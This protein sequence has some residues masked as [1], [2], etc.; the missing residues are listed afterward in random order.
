LLG[1]VGAWGRHRCAHAENLREE[2][3]AHRL[4]SLAAREADHE[5]SDG[6][7]S[8]EGEEHGASHR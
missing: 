6:N 8:F 7:K 1:H 5:H 4:G 3:V 2:A